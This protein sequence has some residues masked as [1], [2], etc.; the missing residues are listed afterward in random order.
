M[1]KKFLRWILSCVLACST[2]F[3][4]G[5]GH[6]CSYT[7]EIA[8]DKY[9]KS[10]ATCTAGT[11]YYYSCECGK[12]GTN[13]FSVGKKVAHSYI[14][15]V[16]EEKYIKSEANCTYAAEYWKSCQ[17]CGKK[18]SF[19]TFSYGETGDC[20]YTEKIVKEDFLKSEATTEQSEEY[21]K[22]CICGKHGEETFFY[23]EKIKTDYTAQELAA[24]TPNSLTVTLYDAQ[25][26]VYGFTYNTMAKPLRPMIQIQEGNEL[27]EDCEEYPVTVVQASTLDLN[28]AEMRYYVSKAEVPL[29]VGKTYTYRVWDK[30]AQVGTETTTIQAKDTKAT[31]FKFAHVSDTQ[32]TKHTPGEDTGRFFRQVLP[33]IVDTNDFIFHTGDMVQE[34]KY[35][36]WTDML[37]SNFEYLSTIPVMAVCGNHEGP[38]KKD[39]HE[40]YE[41]FNNK[42]SEQITDF[43]YYYSFVYGNTKFIMLNTMDGE[44]YALRDGKWLSD[45]QYEW[46][47]NELENNTATWTI[48]GMH[49]TMYAAG[50]WSSN[51]AENEKSVKLRAQLTD[52]FAQHGV[53][54]VLQGHEHIL[55]RSV[56]IN[57]IVNGVPQLQTETIQKENGVDYSI[58]PN[59]TIYVINGHCGNHSNMV[60]DKTSN[61]FT[62]REALTPA[63]WAEFE[64]NGN[65]LTVNVNYYDEAE[66]EKTYATWGIVKN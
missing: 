16:P 55:S 40:N 56:P 28:K 50:H 24:F 5:C 22:T 14:A 60:W 47:V 62:Y 18:S 3:S 26:S 30:Y 54:I 41:H 34:G 9:L 37:H 45:E 51:P 38:Y 27:S 13:T 17:W 36:Y 53:D 11:T 33:A 35:E 32:V 52:L 46:L 48:V 63:S 4:A 43:G 39:R 58:N 42:I 65:K 23:G 25:N 61:W 7:N 19:A 49:T 8:E 64:I 10:E 12:H 57:G 21:Y 66:G 31:S 44:E 6:Q 59:G 1:N 2:L 29:E 20:N 15:E